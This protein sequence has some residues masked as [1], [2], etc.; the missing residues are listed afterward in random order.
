MYLVGEMIQNY[1]ADFLRLQTE[2]GEELGKLMEQMLIH[3]VRLKELNAKADKD[4]KNLEIRERAGLRII[5][6]LASN[7]LKNCLMTL[8]SLT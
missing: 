1:Q 2:Q 5:V 8:N 6:P 4:I 3:D 7:S